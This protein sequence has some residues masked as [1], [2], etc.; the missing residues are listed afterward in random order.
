[1]GG[2]AREKHLF[3]LSCRELG[4]HF[5]LKRALNFGLLPSIYL[6]DEPEEDLASYAG[7]YLK[8][9]IADEGATRN[10][11][12]FS[13]FLEV[14]AI[15]NGQ[16][17]NF[18]KVANDAQVPRSTIQEYYGILKD[19]LIAYELPAWK[20]TVKRKPVGTSKYYFFDVGVARF[21]QNRSVVAPGSK[22]FGECFEAFI[23][24]ELKVYSEYKGHGPLAYWR[25][26][27]GHEVDF[28]VDDKVAV[29]VKATAHISRDDL[30]G[31]RAI[32]EEKKLRQYI[33]MCFVDTPR[34]VDGI[35]VMPWRMAL[36]QLWA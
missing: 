36:D 13:R 22:E 21:L 33:V 3:P 1:M 35:H 2:R 14:A 19:T 27:A 31:L 8:T 34:V 24:Q 10:I 15:S 17:L 23:G 9:E 26:T 7:A 18:T 32:R 5:D 28:I 11:P 20:R 6:S 4:E 29:E 25:S 30:K 12:A 16:M